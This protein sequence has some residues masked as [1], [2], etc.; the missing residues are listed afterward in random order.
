MKRIIAFGLI[1]LA[2]CGPR[3]VHEEP[4]MVNGDRVKGVDDA[5][6]VAETRS[7]A[8]Q[9]AASQRRDSIAAAAHGS[10]RGAVCASL[11]RGE[12]AL[13]MNET[14]V[15]AATRT[16]H[17]AWSVRNSGNSTVMVA[18]RPSLTPRDALGEVAMVQLVD[19]RVGSYSY[20][21]AQGM[22][23]VTSPAEASAE[24]RARAVSETL[25]REGDQLI[26]AG[27]RAAALDRY[28]RAS[29][30]RPNDA[31]LQ[32]RIATLLDQQLRPIEA[33]VR[34]QRFLHQLEIEKIQATGDANAKLA[35][36]IAHARERVIVL[37]RNR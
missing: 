30:L 12:I 27:D 13:G 26:A 34:Y 32:Y 1:A 2:A 14:Q 29:V 36:A 35:N 21:E 33:V 20:R 18:Q 37:E 4:I 28:D 3:K 23:V 8:G 9:I 24:G 11:A 16:T 6:A 31:M 15:M 10:C 22:R 19:G 5:V 25:V 7:E 17:D